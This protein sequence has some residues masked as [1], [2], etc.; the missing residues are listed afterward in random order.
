MAAIRD[1]QLE[2]QREEDPRAGR[3]TGINERS[4]AAPVCYHPDLLHGWPAA[5]DTR[6]GENT[7]G[8]LE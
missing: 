2:L 3:E 7:T 6:L 8:R 4:A 1:A 5:E